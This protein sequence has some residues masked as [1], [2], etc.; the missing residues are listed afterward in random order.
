MST[1]QPIAFDGFLSPSRTLGGCQWTLHCRPGTIAQ[2]A[3]LWFN[4]TED[5]EFLLVTDSSATVPSQGRLGG[6]TGLLDTPRQFTATG[7]SLSVVWTWGD[8]GDDEEPASLW[9]KGFEAT[10]ECVPVPE[11]YLEVTVD[12]P[13][14]AGEV[15]VGRHG[16]YRFRAVQGQT[17]I[18]QTATVDADLDVV[19]WISDGAKVIARSDDNDDGDQV[20]FSPFLD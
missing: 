12:G 18:V 16:L 8:W 19:L 11:D 4:S 9:L 10:A 6:L 2:L 17:Y 13:P 15:E 14:T 5:A 20:R 1:A 3:V 7:H